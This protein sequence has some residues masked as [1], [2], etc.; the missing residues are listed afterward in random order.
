LE[1][2]Q[3]FDADFEPAP[4]V[5][6]AGLAQSILALIAALRVRSPDLPV[7]LLHRTAGSAAVDV[8]ALGAALDTE[9]GRPA[10]RAR[11]HLHGVDTPPGGPINPQHLARVLEEAWRA[12]LGR[13][14]APAVEL[15][16]A[17]PG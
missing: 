4:A 13:P 6:E 10:Q 9:L 15:Q 14:F 3:A 17:H 11:I 8:A 7:L 16:P 12:G 1:A 5:T 2:R